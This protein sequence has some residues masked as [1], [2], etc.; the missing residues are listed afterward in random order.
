MVLPHRIELWT[1]P[2][3][4]G[5]STTELRQRRMRAGGSRTRRK[6]PQGFHLRKDKSRPSGRLR[7]LCA[8]AAL[9]PPGALPLRER[10][11]TSRQETP[12]KA[13]RKPG[14]SERLA[15][16]LRANL[17]RRKVQARARNNAEKPSSGGNSSRPGEPEPDFRRNR[18][19]TNWRLIWSENRFPSRILSG[20]GL[21]GIKRRGIGE[22]M[23][24]IRI[25]G[26]SPLIGSIPISGAKNAALPLM[27]ASCSP[28]RR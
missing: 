7:L 18:A 8:P 2:L 24:R 23:D 12:P 21:F 25:V 10:M 19:I 14:R 13:G 11:T 15:A 28:S 27:I 17:R 5:C 3:P 22:T 1:S 16:E 20:T 26:G 6:L 9:A 4:R